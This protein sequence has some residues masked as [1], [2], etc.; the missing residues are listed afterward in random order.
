M[1]YAGKRQN[2]EYLFWKSKHNMSNNDKYEEAYNCF[3]LCDSI[4]IVQFYP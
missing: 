4:K 1:D 3:Q 2:L